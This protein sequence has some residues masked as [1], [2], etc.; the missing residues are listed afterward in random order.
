MIPNVITFT[1]AKKERIG[2]VITTIISAVLGVGG[3]YL[4]GLI[5][6]GGGRFLIITLGV[7]SLF[8]ML[9]CIYGLIRLKMEEGVGMYISDAGILDI[10]TGNTYGTINWEDVE[11][12]QIMDDISNLKRKYIVVKVKNPFEYIQ[13]EKSMAK[14]RTL[15]LKLQYYGSPI[16]FS[17]RTLNCTFDALKDSVFFKYNQYKEKQAEKGVDILA[18]KK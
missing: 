3:I 11:A 5:K 2:L 13:R 16:C 12:I 7:F 1:L 17:T 10:S 18:D 9:F 14:K 8:V 4:A 15:E 6:F